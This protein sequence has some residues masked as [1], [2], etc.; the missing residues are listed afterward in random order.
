MQFKS[1]IT[2]YD[3]DKLVR[4]KMKKGYIQISST[5]LDTIWPSFEEEMRLKLSFEVLAGRVK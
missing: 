5:K 1:D 4:T 3:L 2:G